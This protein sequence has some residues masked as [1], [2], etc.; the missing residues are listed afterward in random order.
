MAEWIVYIV[1]CQDQSL[2]TGVAKDV[3]ARVSAHNAGRGA[4]YTHSRRPVVLVYQE[5]AESYGAALQREHAIK[6]MRAEPKRKLIAHTRS[7]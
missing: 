3:E 7:P 2:Y 4:K 5:A 1:R 6:R